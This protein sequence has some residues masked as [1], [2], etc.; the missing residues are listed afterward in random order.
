MGT[1]SWNRFSE[2]EQKWIKEAA[3]ESSIY[4]RRLWA[5]SEMASLR[6][7][8][9]A[10]VEIIY[11][12]KELFEQQTLSM[13]ELFQEEPEILLLIEQIRNETEN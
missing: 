8:E 10:G 2:Q 13:T 5:E 1:G 9:K 7:I 11:P 3:V 4:Q 12:D 6:A